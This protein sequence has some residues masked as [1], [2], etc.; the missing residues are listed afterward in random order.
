MRQLDGLA[1]QHFFE[2]ATGC[3]V[4]GAYVDL[5]LMGLLRTEFADR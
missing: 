5:V 2:R 3:L 1:A 4:D